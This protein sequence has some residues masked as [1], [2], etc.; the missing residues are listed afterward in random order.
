MVSLFWRSSL[1]CFSFSYRPTCPISFSWRDDGLLF[2]SHLCC[3]LLSLMSSSPNLTA[4][5]M[6]PDIS[7]FPALMCMGCSLSL[8]VPLTPEVCWS[9]TLLSLGAKS[10]SLTPLVNALSILATLIW[11]SVKRA[12]EHIHVWWFSSSK[13]LVFWSSAAI[14]LTFPSSCDNLPWNVLWI[15]SKP[16]CSQCG[17]PLLLCSSM[18]PDFVT[19]CKL[20]WS[21]TFSFVKM[22]DFSASNCGDSVS[23]GEILDW[24]LSGDEATELQPETQLHADLPSIPA[25]LFLRD[26][27]LK[28]SKDNRDFFWPSL[29]GIAEF[30][31]SEEAFIL[32]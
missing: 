14:W 5:L 21:E 16:G 32:G 31:D 13:T 26:S 9:V 24:F 8:K 7:A 18:P 20:I 10:T 27:S 2:R 4:L 17:S 25:R 15:L 6:C 3:K 28:T 29:I 22:A 12:L 1:P 30:E 19:F 23:L 11:M